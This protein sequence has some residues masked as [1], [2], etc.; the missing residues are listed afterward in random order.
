VPDAPKIDAFATAGAEADKAK[1]ALLQA[2]AESG[3]SGRNAYLA[4]ESSIQQQKQSALGQA[5]GRANAIGA[6]DA[7]MSRQAETISRPLDMLSGSLSAGRAQFDSDIARQSADASTYFD[8]VKAAVPI[9]QAQSQTAVQSLLANERQVSADRQAGLTEALQ[10]R[11]DAERQ[12]QF[13]AALQKM[14]REQADVTWQREQERMEFERQMEQ[15]DLEG[16]RLGLDK[17]RTKSSEESDKSPLAQLVSQL[18]GQTLAKQ[19][20]AP[21][22]QQAVQGATTGVGPS[23]RPYA[24]TTGSGGG[25][26]RSYVDHGAVTDGLGAQLGLNPG[27]LGGLLGSLAP[28]YQKPATAAETAKSSVEAIKATPKFQSESREVAN[29]LASKPKGMTEGA[30]KSLI[31]QQIR[32]NSDYAKNRAIYEQVIKDF[33]L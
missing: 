28:G 14:Q 11:M 17:A 24:A 13:Q 25:I 16:A 15:F 21:I 9:V 20:L 3:T 22:A 23:G 32:E 18:G 7:F 26:E 5:A 12:R 33:R 1:L 31:K 30:Y 27:E 2:V 8:K 4:A 10:S 19:Q 29:A 6:P